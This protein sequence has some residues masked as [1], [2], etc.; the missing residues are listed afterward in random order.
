M[1]DNP[2]DWSIYC[3]R[4][5]IYCA[6]TYV[7]NWTI[8]KLESIATVVLKSGLIYLVVLLGLCCITLGALASLIY[9][10]RQNLA[11]Y[12]VSVLPLTLK[13]GVLVCLGNVAMHFHNNDYSNLSNAQKQPSALLSAHSL[14]LKAKNQ[15][16]HHTRHE[17]EDHLLTLTVQSKFENSAELESSCRTWN[18]LVTGFHLG[19]LSFLLM[20]V[21]KTFLTVVKIYNVGPFIV[22]QSVY[23]VIHLPYYC[24]CFT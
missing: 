7:P 9:P 11:C 16:A 5:F 3:Y 8:S 18:R 4:W 22:T 17:C 21:S 1:N 10:R 12:P 23:C 24:T 6:F 2:Y 15:L 13:L 19:Q 20:A 14:H